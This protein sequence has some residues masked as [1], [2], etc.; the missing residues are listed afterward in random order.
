MYNKSHEK[1]VIGHVKP[2]TGHVEQV[3]CHKKLVVISHDKNEILK[4]SHTTN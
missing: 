2:I 3:T 4:N 1:L